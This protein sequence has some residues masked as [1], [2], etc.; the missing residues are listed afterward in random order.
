N[1]E[2]NNNNDKDVE[3]ELVL[4]IPEPFHPQDVVLVKP[5]KQDEKIFQNSAKIEQ[6]SSNN[7]NQT[8]KNEEE[9][10]QIIGI[11]K[12]AVGVSPLRYMVRP[13]G[14]FTGLNVNA[15]DKTSTSVDG[16]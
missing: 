11:P 7:N 13:I 6:S 8:A 12:V 4:L 3:H 1:D 2:I 9:I 10:Q 16:A 5:R 14:A 15:A